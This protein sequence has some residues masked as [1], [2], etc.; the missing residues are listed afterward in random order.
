MPLLRA[1]GIFRHEYADTTLREHLGLPRPLSRYA[2][3][4]VAEALSA[5][6]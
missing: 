2:E 1:R 6:A 5:R 3:A 4:P